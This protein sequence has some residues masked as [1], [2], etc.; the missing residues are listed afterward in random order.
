MDAKYAELLPRKSNKLKG[1]FEYAT[2][3]DRTNPEVGTIEKT[4][5]TSGLE[6]A[7]VTVKPTPD[8]L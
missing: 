8:P 3:D 1:I 7:V 5:P 4:S 2:K 6:L